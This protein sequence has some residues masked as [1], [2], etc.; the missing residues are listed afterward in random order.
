VRQRGWIEPVRS[1]DAA[2]DDR[3][4]R[5]RASFADRLGLG[6]DARLAELRLA[7]QGMSDE[8]LF[9][10]IESGV[11]ERH[12]LVV[13]R[14]RPDG[15]ARELADVAR[16]YRL[17]RALAGSGIPI[18]EALWH[19][20]GDEPLGAPFFVMR[21]VVGMV[22]VPWSAEGRKFLAAA[23]D[24]AIGREFV[25]VLARIHATD[26][27][28]RD[29]AFLPGSEDG[30]GFALREVERLADSVRRYREDPEPVF[31]D[32]LGWLAAHAPE[33][34]SPTLVHGDY[35]T[36]NLIYRVAG[37]GEDDRIAA[38]LDWE[39]ARIGDPF[40][41]LGWVCARSNA[42]ES[43]RVCYLLPREVFLERYARATGR[44]ID[45]SRLRFWEVFHQVRNGMIWLSA[46]EAWRSGRT[47]DL[48]LARW[49]LTLPTMRRMILELLEAAP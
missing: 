15:V 8:T 6:A 29:L 4:E 21:R 48:R 11:G 26:W 40:V 37:G 20:P 46:A 9:V 33:T 28:A 32:A 49:S 27:R 16:Q 3:R 10:T 2:E 34:P 13:R 38:V 22:P 19:E 14:F 31:E 25:E 30:R 18:A 42:M 35:R 47:K 45:E 17:L 5:I 1:K 12:E 41:D 24:G 23:G 7:S 43:D 36:G 44:E 39:F